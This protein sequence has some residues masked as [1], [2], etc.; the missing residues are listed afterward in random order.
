M[1]APQWFT[2]IFNSFS[3]SPLLYQGV[4]FQRMKKKK[5]NKNHSQSLVLQVV[6]RLVLIVR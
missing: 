6:M 4:R 1:I 3:T 2:M 5:F